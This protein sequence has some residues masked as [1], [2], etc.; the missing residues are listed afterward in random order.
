LISRAAKNFG[1]ANK[2][3]AFL[4]S[5]AAKTF[6]NCA[7]K[8]SIWFSRAEEFLELRPKTLYLFSRAEKFFGIATKSTVLCSAQPRREIFWN[9]D[10]KHCTLF[11]REEKS[12]GIASKSTTFCSAVQGICFQLW[13]KKAQYFVQPRIENFG[14]YQQQYHKLNLFCPAAQREFFG[15]CQQEQVKLTAFRSAALR[16]FLE[17]RPKAVYSVQPR[18]ENFWNCD[19]KHRILFS[20]TTKIL[21]L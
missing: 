16:I 20:R 11:S 13:T 12:V 18:S 14:I 10:P 8:H 7:H 15:I 3:T 21:E 5:R 2:S 9:C 17:L 4:F 1:I 6:W 19:E